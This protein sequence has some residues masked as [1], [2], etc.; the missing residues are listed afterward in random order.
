MNREKL[1]LAAK[2]A[3]LEVYFTPLSNGVRIDTGASGNPYTDHGD[4]YRLARA[5]GMMIDFGFG[6]LSYKIGKVGHGM[7]FSRGDDASE[8][9]AIVSAAAEIGRAMK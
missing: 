2:A 3:G 7:M 1:E 9:E 5:C 8:A 4:R 6:E